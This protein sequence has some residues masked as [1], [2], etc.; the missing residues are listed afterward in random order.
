MA[1]VTLPA[2]VLQD[3]AAHLYRPGGRVFRDQSKVL[4]SR[5]AVNMTQESPPCLY[6]RRMDLAK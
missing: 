6:P 3:L 5:H 2:T 4:A 1:P